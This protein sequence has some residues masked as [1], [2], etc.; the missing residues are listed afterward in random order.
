MAVIPGYMRQSGLPETTGVRGLPSVK[1]DDSIGRSLSQAGQVGQEIGGQLLQAQA[2]SEVSV[3]TVNAQL[4]LANVERELSTMDGLA[5]SEAY[6][7]RRQEIYESASAGI[8]SKKGRA[9]FDKTYNLLSTKSLISI[10][11]DGAKRKIQQLGGVVVQSLDNLRR[12]LGPKG[13]NPMERSLADTTG[14]DIIDRAVK[15]NV[16][17]AVKGEK[18]YRKFK[19]GLA[20]SG[21]NEI[22]RTSPLEDLDKLADNMALD[23]FPPK[24]EIGKLWES[25]DDTDKLS[26]QAKVRSSYERHVNTAEKNDRNDVARL[27]RNQTVTF[28]GHIK[29]IIGSRRSVPGEAPVEAPTMTQ[30]LTDL[31][32]KKISSDQFD[33]LESRLNNED[34]VGNTQEAVKGFIKAIREATNAAD[35]ESVITEME[36]SLGANG[37]ISFKDFQTLEARARAAK[38]GTAGERI[39]TSY[40]KALQ[41]IVGSLDM[42]DKMLPGAKERASMVLLDFEGRLATPGM[43]PHEAFLNAIDAFKTRESVSLNSIPR[44]QFGPRDKKLS[45]WTP[46]HV[47]SA[48]AET[49][50]KFKGTPAVLGTQ[51]MILNTLRTYIEQRDAATKSG[52]DTGKTNKEQLDDLRKK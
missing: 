40:S 37:R 13:I 44:P 24:S 46:E 14:R 15:S 42:W 35:I 38:P 19:S 39:K 32:N 31:A 1:I 28:A 45:E 21:L 18:M 16:I 27:K 5:A 3:A 30:L 9:A 43:N 6:A 34:P 48:I 41:R 17:S 8:T 51:M 36:N 25:L 20:K 12:G 11:S 49:K 52:D 26:M 4:K 47:E 29:K 10:Q 7:G 33:K 2:E 23:A 50:S 22:I